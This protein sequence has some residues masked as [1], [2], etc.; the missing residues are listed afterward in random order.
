MLRSIRNIFH[1]V[2][3]IL[4][5]ARYRALFPL[6]YLRFSPLFLLPFRYFPSK[7]EAQREGERLAMALEALGPSFIKLGQTLS[8]RSDLVGSE[9]ANDLSRLQDKLPPFPTSQAIN[10]IEA[11]LEAPITTLFSSFN[12]EP[13]AAASIAQVH[14][15][16]TM[17]GKKVAVKVLR[18]GIREA[19]ARDIDLFFWLATLAERMVKSLKRLKPVEVIRTFSE[20]VKLEMDLRFEAAAASELKENCQNDAHLYVPEVDWGRTSRNVFTLEWI[21]GIPI[22]D[23]QALIEAG[24]DLSQLAANLA[25]CFF[26][27]AY[28]DG[29][30]HGDMHP[31]NL[32]IGENG[33]IIVVD[34]GI[35]GRL[36]NATRIYVAEILRGFLSRD[37]LHVAQVHFD[38]GYVPASKSLETFAQACRSI[39]EPIVGL[40]VNQISIARLLSQ[41]FAITEDFEMETQPQLLLLQKTMMLVEGVGGM[42]NPNVN[43]WQLAE[44]WIEA[45]VTRN[46]GLKAQLERHITNTLRFMNDFPAFIGNVQQL[47]NTISNEGLKL[48]PS[49]VSAVIRETQQNNTLYWKVFLT[50]IAG[51]ALGTTV[52][53]HFHAG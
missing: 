12:Q 45:W 6:K 25:V 40:P 27:Q 53:M 43:M 30:F 47:S 34:F 24:H 22:H 49:T 21:E 19:F 17:E 38:A 33:D 14:Q 32:F 28:R 1:L 5:L 29:F 41:L 42:L 7:Q 51:A 48:H 11:E 44:P 50:A 20:S 18:P 10:I 15:A 52:I 4:V 36:D 16:V 37:Y 13:V 8:T 35:M 46:M 3:I 31:G 2:R 23:R 26:N 39:G 9:I